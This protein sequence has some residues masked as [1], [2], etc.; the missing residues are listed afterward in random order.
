MSISSRDVLRQFFL[1]GYHELR[2]RLTRRLGSVELASDA[3]H[4]TW[5][6][7]EN[8]ASTVT[9]LSP[10]Q[11]LLQMA[12]N[13]ALKRRGAESRFVTLTDAKMAIGLADDE[14]DPERASIAR[15]ELD[16][17]VRALAELT[18][19]RRDILLASRLKDVPL[20]E[21]AENLGI[22]QRLVEIELKHALA[23][24]ELRLERKVIRRFG[25]K[26]PDESPTE[27]GPV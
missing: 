23:H 27:Q 19:R 25:P 22:S 13:V 11:Y 24:C 14:P 18:P 16:A 21:I 6:R 1:H 3:L 20:R 7:I 26:Q 10:K 5:L 8:V 2:I 12:G 17:L 9:V 15:S 4:E